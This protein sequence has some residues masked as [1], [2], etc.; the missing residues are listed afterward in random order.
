MTSPASPYR[1]PSPATRAGQF[2]DWC[3]LCRR[4]IPHWL[5]KEPAGAPFGECVT[6]KNVHTS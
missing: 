6:C 2:N 5:R 3:L 1:G 4:Y